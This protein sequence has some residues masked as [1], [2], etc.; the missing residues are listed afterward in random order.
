MAQI[1]LNY[2]NIRRF[3]SLTSYR[4]LKKATDEVHAEAVLMTS[5]GRYTTGNLARSLKKRTWIVRG[6]A[7]SRVWSDL[8]YARWVHDGTPRHQIPI[9]WYPGRRPRLKFFWRRVNATVFFAKVNH[10]GQ[11]GKQFLTIPL[12]RAARRN[13]MIV[14]VK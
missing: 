10:P 13:N 5:H 12:I 2:P 9:P 4:Y 11:R 7:E 3:S 6:G 14:I 8:D 1:R